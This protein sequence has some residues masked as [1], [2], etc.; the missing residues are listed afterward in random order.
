MSDDEDPNLMAFKSEDCLMVSEL[1]KAIQKIAERAVLEED[2]QR[3][4][5]VLLFGM[6]RLPHATPGLGVRLALKVESGGDS[7][8]VE[9]HLHG[10]ELTLT[11]GLW[12]Q[13]DAHTEIVFDVNFYGRDGDPFAALGFAG[14][15][16][17]CV[18][19]PCRTVELEETTWE[20]FDD[21][22]LPKATG[23]EWADMDSDFV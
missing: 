20:P 16:T 4:L 2:E 3:L 22:D 8:W 19:D 6:K 12:E 5:K 17:D 21:W 1:T 18:L 7:N 10:D 23:S 9:V 13:G 14:R 11:Q 15:F